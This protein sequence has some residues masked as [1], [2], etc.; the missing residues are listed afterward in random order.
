M[1]LAIFRERP[2]WSLTLALT[3]LMELITIAMR[4]AFGQSAADY[5]AKANLPL[6][7][8]M[9]HMFWSVPFA[10]ASVLVSGRRSST[11]LWS[12]TLALIASDLSHHF[13]VLPV[14]V[15]HTGWHWP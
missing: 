6:L 9:H 2:F 15:G 1:N 11:I 5:I 10:I 8:Q 7:L 3:V 13:L 4:L 12:I 14:W